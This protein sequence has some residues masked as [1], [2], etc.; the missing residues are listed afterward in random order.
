[1][2]RTRGIDIKG[3]EAVKRNL[4]SLK[5]KSVAETRRGLYVSAEL[6]MTQSKKIVPVDTGALRST[7]HVKPPV[8]TPGRIEIELG[9]GGPAGKG[10]KAGK[11]LGYGIWVHE[12][13][14]AQ[15][16]VGEAKFLQKP[17]EIAAPGVAAALV[18]SLHKLVESYHG[19]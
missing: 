1:M 16:K 15:H 17:F 12:R 18:E 10:D 5:S 14:D 19:A 8:D 2:P 3:L 4:E 7:G 6:I 13:M 11:D 9:Y